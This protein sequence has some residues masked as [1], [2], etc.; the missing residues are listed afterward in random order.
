[1]D[2]EQAVPITLPKDEVPTA[3]LTATED[4]IKVAAALGRVMA[5]V[6]IGA[7]TP[8]PEELEGGPDGLMAMA[9]VACPFASSDG[10]RCPLPCGPAR[11]TPPPRDRTWLPRD[12]FLC[13]GGD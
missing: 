4:P 13:D 12:E 5:I 2:P 6:R 7:R 8:G 10:G 11:G 9:R 3:T 1:E